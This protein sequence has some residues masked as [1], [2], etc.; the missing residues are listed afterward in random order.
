MA[1][2]KS[3][4]GLLGNICDFPVSELISDRLAPRIIKSGLRLNYARTGRTVLRRCD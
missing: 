3:S 4:H 2:F 1:S